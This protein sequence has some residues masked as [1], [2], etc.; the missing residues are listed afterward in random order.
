M[1]IGQWVFVAIGGICVALIVIGLVSRVQNAAHSAKAS[2]H[3]E[4]DG[5]RDYTQ[6]VS[7]KKRHMMPDE[8]DQDVDEEYHGKPAEEAAPAEEAP[9]AEANPDAVSDAMAELY[10]EAAQPAEEDVTYTRRRKADKE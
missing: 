7:S 6:A 10:P 5:Y 9:A 4:R 3:L 8:E 2:D 1:S